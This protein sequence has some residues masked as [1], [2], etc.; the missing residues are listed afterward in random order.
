MAAESVETISSSA[1]E[2]LHAG[3]LRRSLKLILIAWIF[4]AFWQWTISGAAMTRFAIGLDTPVWAFGVLAMIP[5]LAGI[6]QLPASFLLE[7]FGRRKAVFITAMSLSRASWVLIAA[8]PWL[9]PDAR[10]WWWPLLMIT[11]LI[12]W[13]LAHV[14]VPA[15]MNWMADVIPTRV[16]GR[17]FGKRNRVGQIVGIVATIGIGFLMDAAE[18]IGSTSDIDAGKIMMLTTSVILA[19]AGLLGVLDI[20]CFTRVPDSTTPP[21]TEKI[22][23]RAFISRPLRDKQFRYFLGFN[24]L[25]WMGIGSM[26]QYLWLFLFDVIKVSNH[27]ANM[28]LVALPL[29][30][31]AITYPVWGRLVDRVGCRPVLIISAFLSALGPLGWMMIQPGLIWPGYLVVFATIMIWPG[32][33]IASFNLLLGIAGDNQGGSAYVACNALA[34]GLGGIC[35]GIVASILAAAFID[36][37]WSIPS[38]HLVVTYHTLIIFMSFVVR[39]LAV[40][41]ALGIE[42]PTAHKTQMVIKYM[43]STLHSNVRTFIMQPNRMM[44]QMVRRVNRSTPPADDSK[45]DL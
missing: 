8:I 37:S 10:A 30:G 33:E 11:V 2:P 34:V 40:P 5:P 20:Q 44:T 18:K 13:S 31:F 35:S 6:L 19:F 17:Y 26:T 23:W 29:A 45:S 36:L 39:M 42:E 38:L 41:L 14:A 12:S 27:T 32:V 7:R 28:L 3:G 16:R 25:L 1:M 24:F 21:V 4:G 15:W 22:H 9:L 43:S